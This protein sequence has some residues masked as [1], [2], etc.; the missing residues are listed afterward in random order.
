MFNVG[1]EYTRDEIHR[2]LGGSKQ[3]YLPT[4]K[5][6]F[7]AV[8]LRLD[9]NPRAPHVV[10][11]GRGPII[12]AAGLALSNQRGP[13]PVFIKRA[14]NRWEYMGMFIVAGSYTDGQQFDALIAG[15]SRRQADVSRAIQLKQ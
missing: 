12:A 4:V 14:S 5:S 6:R 8:C 10:L 13:V 2:K 1:H 11:C 15:S 9:L 7:V 3:S